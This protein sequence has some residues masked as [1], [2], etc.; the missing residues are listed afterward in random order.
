[1]TASLDWAEHAARSFEP[2]VRR[3]ATP[4]ALARQCDPTVLQ[5]PALDLIDRAAAGVLFGDVTRQQI[6]APPQTGKS[7]RI[8]RWTPLCALADDPTLRIALISADAELARRWGRAIRRDVRNNPDLGITLQA[9]SQAAGRW[10]TTAGGELFCAGYATGTTGRPIDLLIID[11]P[12][13]DRAA[14]ESE[15]IRDRVWEFWEN[16]G[17][18]RARRVILMHTRWHD[19]DLAGR[20]IKREPSEWSVLSIPA[21]AE[22]D[23]DP[24]GRDIGQEI[25]SANPKLHP[26]GYYPKMEA[27]TSPYVWASL[28]QQRPQLAQGN[29]FKRG[30]WQYWELLDGERARLDGDIFDLRDAYRY[31]T[32]D[33]ATS[34]KTSADWTVAT[35]WAVMPNG[36][37]LVLDRKR[38]R[39]PE[40]DHAAFIAPLRQQWLQPFDVT[41]VES[42]MFGTRLVYA[43]GEAGVPIAE[44]HADTDKLTRAL[45]YAALVRQHRVWLPR[46]A[47]WL[48]EWREEHAEFGPKA[49]HDDQVDTGAYGARVAL[50]YWAP[51]S[52]D[53]DVYDDDLGYERVSI[54]PD[55]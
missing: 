40:V 20:L 15:T 14:A 21:I 55:L 25:Q 43:M 13:K 34:T 4:G 12:F 11:D 7:Q 3:F 49:K 30:D 33:L 48:D 17:G 39:V 35:A 51:A 1:M 10:E 38:E 42:R 8:S 9:D 23:D 24:L 26:P 18:L 6:Y 5:T 50:D 2:K 37:L 36:A 46:S 54:G 29:I 53:G 31:I 32:I 27:K 28:Y 44:L 52:P 41:H 16:D 45:P 47:P 22:T 19:D